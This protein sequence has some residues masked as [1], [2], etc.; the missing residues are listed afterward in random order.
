MKKTKIIA[1]IVLIS[2]PM[3]GCGDMKSFFKK[4]SRDQRYYAK[5]QKFLQE[6]EL[7]AAM[8]QLV[9]AIRTN[10]QYAEAYT[11]IGD[12]HRKNGN[13]DGAAKN[14]E[15]ACKINRF[16]FRPHYNLG[17]TYQAMGNLTR[18]NRRAREYQRK[19]VHVY[20]RAV[21][22][23]P[24]SF[25][26]Q[27]NL[28]ACYF[29]LGK[30]ELAQQQTIKALKIRPYSPK[31]NNNLAIMLEDRG[32][33]EK[34]ILSYK[35]SLE[36]DSKQPVTMLN[37]GSI[38]FRMGRFQ[39]AL[40]TYRS[41]TRLAP[42]MAEAYEQMGACLYRM[43]RP[44][45]AQKA[46]VTAISKK[47]NSP[48]AHRGLGVA[49]MSKYIADNS[50]V[51]MKNKALRAWDKSL[52]LQP[53]QRDLTSLMKRL[54]P[55]PL[56]AGLSKPATKVVPTL[57]TQRA[58]AVVTTPKPMR[59]QK[60]TAVAIKPAPVKREVAA[61]SRPEPMQREI[62]LPS[63]PAPMR[64][65]AVPRARPKPTPVVTIESKP[66]PWKSAKPKS[67]S[68]I[69]KNSP[70]SRMVDSKTAP[71]PKPKIVVKQLSHSPKIAAK[72]FS[73][74]S[75]VSKIPPQGEPEKPTEIWTPHPRLAKMQPATDR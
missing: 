39:S 10:P 26:A 45:D 8:E 38:Y 6:G 11:A 13:Y 22:L 42:D 56:T 40:A 52:K 49:C 4:K 29:Q 55:V 9:K 35:T 14:Y 23:L 2:L 27:L 7:D 71:T 59:I 36:A 68:L 3:V 20:I 41:A 63:R 53:N 12:I 72:K 31:A 25:D 58:K 28:G 17:V 30:H 37:L 18:S 47:P 69:K 60:I 5:G 46:F 34:A 19:A 15:S 44:D 66:T 24:S 51:D 48:G 73:S 74:V 1:I 33:S 61:P 43:K 64:R 70:A 50:R 57:T 54:G 62:A 75:K 67:I 65:V 32:E 21:A 16:E